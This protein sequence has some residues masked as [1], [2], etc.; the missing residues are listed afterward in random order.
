MA[1][2]RCHRRTL[3]AAA[4]ALPF[5]LCGLSAQAQHYPHKPIT[6]VV[7][8]AAG[9]AADALARAWGDFIG[10]SL[11]AAVVVDNKTGANGSIAAAYVAKQVP[12][13]YTILLGSTSNMSLNPFSYKS[14]AYSPT[15]DFDPVLMLAGTNQVIVANPHAGIKSVAD[16]VRLAKAKPDTIAFGS[17]GKGNSTHLSVAFLAQHYGIELTHVPY[18]GAAPALMGVMGGET[19]LMSDALVTAVPQVK[20]GKVVPLVIMGLTRSSALPDVPTVF[21]LGMKDFPA[22][23]WYGLMVPRGT[24]KAVV[25]LL[26]A[27]TKKFWADPAVKA[28]MEAMYMEPPT[29]L[30]PEA[31]TQTMQREAKVWGPII[32]KLDIQND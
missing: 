6:L 9:G 11:G 15:K 20:S 31:V 26:N 18:R 13:G 22:G 32:R 4:L 5:A 27:E 8:V 29:E 28:R 16:L 10:K 17:A 7:P 30:G 19:Q 21:E 25:Q 14:L 23:G 24:P 3:A 2:H 12:D 1:L